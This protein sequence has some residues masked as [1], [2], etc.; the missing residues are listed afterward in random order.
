MHILEIQHPDVYDRFKREFHVIRRSDRFW[1]GLLSDLVIEQILM[2]TL[3]TTGRLTHGQQMS[4]A[5]CTQWL[6]SIPVCADVNMA[7]QMFTKER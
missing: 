2:R 4:E 5:Q 6:L 7:M 3:K 1:G